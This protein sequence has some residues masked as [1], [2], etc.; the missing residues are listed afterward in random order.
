M[1]DCRHALQ[2]AEGEGLPRAVFR[3]KIT[4]TNVSYMQHE[5]KA[6]GEVIYYCGTPNIPS[7]FKSPRVA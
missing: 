5:I 3:G 6:A 4:D 7:S 1:I 2:R